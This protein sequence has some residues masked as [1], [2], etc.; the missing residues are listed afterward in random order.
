L[1][2]DPYNLRE[3]VERLFEKDSNNVEE[4]DRRLVE[5]NVLVQYHCAMQQPS[6]AKAIR[7][8]GLKVHGLVYDSEHRSCVRLV[9]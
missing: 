8:R 9:I 4:H 6:V 7:E 2:S 5:L 3:L 1:R